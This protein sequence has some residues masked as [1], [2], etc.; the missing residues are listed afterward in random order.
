MVVQGVLEVLI[1]HIV[2]KVIVEAGIVDSV[3]IDMSMGMRKELLEE[4]VVL[5]GVSGV[6]RIKVS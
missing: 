5:L 2:V 3:Y 6:G 4:G 1:F